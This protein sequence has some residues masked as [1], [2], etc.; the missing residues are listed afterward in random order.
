MTNKKVF[1]AIDHQIIP[2]PEEVMPWAPTYSPDGKYILF[3]DYNGGSEWMMEANGQ[4]LKCITGKMKG[5]P[6]FF[7][8]F[9]YIL[10]DKRMFL[11]NEL[12]DTAVILECEPSVYDWETYQWMP[13]DI[14]GD[15]TLGRLCIGR[16]TYHMAPD[17]KH[18]AYNILCPEGLVMVMCMLERKE[19]KY[20][21]TDYYCLNPEGPVSDC[22]TDQKHW[23]N[24]GT[25]T[26]FKAFCDG[27]RGMLFVTEGDGGNIDQYKLEFESG[28]IT[29]LTTDADW[30]EDG[31]VS[32][33]GEHTVCASWRTMEQLNVLNCVPGSLPLLS[34]YL[35]S[36]IAVHYVSSFPGFA[37][38][39]Q[40]WLLSG[41]DVMGQ[42]LSPYHGGSFITVNNIAGHPMWSLDSTS[43]LLQERCLTP[44][45]V[46]A[47]ERVLEKGMA[48]NRIHIAKLRK[49][50]A[51]TMPIVESK[52]GSWAKRLSEYHANADYPGEHVIRGA[53]SGTVKLVVDGNLL[54]CNDSVSYENFSN[55]G[56]IFLNG[57]EIV[58]GTIADM[59]WKQRIVVTDK[60]DVQIGE[61]DFDLRFQKK[62]PAPSRDIPP[63]TVTGHATST[64]KGMTRTGLPGFGPAT[65]ALPKA[66]ALKIRTE[67]IEKEL[68]VYITSDIY[69]DIRPV[70]G[71]EVAFDGQLCITD[72]DGKVKFKAKNGTIEAKAGENFYPAR[73][74]FFM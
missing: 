13:I 22:D 58:A 52:V 7:G 35:G 21:A 51:Q 15:A 36:V 37:N 38:D 10:D 6:D 24:G 41:N 14:S 72:M 60:A 67:L 57:T 9:Y 1:Y 64:W 46:D 53:V 30:D 42:P 34:F 48:P 49:T 2:L 45:S 27:G 68:E 16:R 11:S 44:P 26:E 33:D 59:I 8:G 19:E 74:G 20:V 71:A 65:A 31:A 56:E 63:M 61:T 25:L 32:P 66:S 17:G 28:K 23:V 12:G 39:L 43:V 69:G 4:N 70:S 62:N 47:N 40:P 5:R 54:N 29:R 50:P 55:D 3:H 73:M 18:L